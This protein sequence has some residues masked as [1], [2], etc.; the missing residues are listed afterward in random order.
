METG[1]DVPNANIII[2]DAD[3]L[4]LYSF[5]SFEGRMEGAK[6]VLCFHMYTN[7]LIGGSVSRRLKAIRVWTGSRNKIAMRDLE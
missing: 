2:V 4:G 6:E 1:L 7:K 5:I 3:R